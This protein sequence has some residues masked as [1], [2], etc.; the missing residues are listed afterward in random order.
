MPRSSVT[1]RRVAALAGV[2]HQTVSR[3]ING[4][5]LVSPETAARVRAAI[6]QL[7]YQPNAIARFMARGHTQTFACLAP[8]LIDYTFACVIDGAEAAVRSHGYY[9]MSASAP[10]PATFASL[11]EEFVG[12]GQAE[13]ILVINPFAD[14]R[15][16]FLPAGFPTVLIGARPRQGIADSVA[17][18]D[19]EAGRLAT[20]YLIDLGHR[21]I[22]TVTGPLAEDCAQ[23]R[24]AGYEET[25]ARQG[26]ELDRNLVVE[27]DWSAN[28]G[29]RALVE[30]MRTGRQPTAIFAQNDLMAAGALRAAR[31]LYIPVPAQLSVIGVD[32]I[33]LATHLEPPLTTV[34]QDF[35]LIGREAARLLLR[36]VE[37]RAAPPEHARLLPALIERRSCQAVDPARAERSRKPGPALEMVSLMNET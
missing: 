8:N 25:L 12:T 31:D 19:L 27:G 26:L 34:R 18:D 16:R 17:L 3:V 21:R 32:D 6:H 13:G 28:A 37:R 36:A 22:A 35:G 5:D 7:G 11:V 1:I 29:Y 20:Q 30:V 4:S 2:S 15:H 23:D 24:L 33:P 14:D 9:L 10:D